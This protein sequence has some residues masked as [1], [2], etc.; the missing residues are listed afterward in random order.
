[1]TYRQT[2]L[3]SSS[4]HTWTPHPYTFSNSSHTP[5][6]TS[7]KQHQHFRSLIT[8]ILLIIIISLYDDELLHHMAVNH[9]QTHNI[10]LRS[11][12]ST[13]PLLSDRLHV[14]CPIPCCWSN[15][16]Q[17]W[18]TTA[19]LVLRLK[20]PY[21]WES[22]SPLSLIYYWFCILSELTY[23]WHIISQLYKY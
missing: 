15:I 8:N 21:L 22:N 2:G 12:V 23:Y 1:M 3:P 5:I 20:V 13:Y 16:S 6:T 18:L 10:L 14:L 9:W 17:P 4:W 19:Q 11:W 7:I